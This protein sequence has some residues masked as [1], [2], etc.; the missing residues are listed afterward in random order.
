MK[1]VKRSDLP[2]FSPGQLEAVCKALADTDTGL[3]GT[4]I[5]QVLQQCRIAEFD[6]QA[7]KWRRLY[8]ALAQRLNKDQHS[9]A[10][11]NFITHSL[12]PARYGGKRD[13]FERRRR[14]VNLPLAFVGLEFGPDGKFRKVGRAS[15]LD[16]A[17]RRA[18]GLRS[19]L[20]D[21]NVHPDVLAYCRAELVAD[22]Y[23]HAVLEATKSVA[24][25]LRRLSGLTTDGSD[26]VD[27]ALLGRA[28]L[29]AINKLTSPSDWSEQRGFGSLVKGVFGTFRNP[30]A[31]EPRTEWAM[32]EE[33]ALDLLVIASY[34]HR[35]LDRS[36]KRT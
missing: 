22:N 9:N 30:T 33:D 35:R 19:A 13:S 4:E 12:D 34:A 20:T 24:V 8:G 23:F 36:S 14:E 28:P 15:T 17:E 25:K 1:Q 21:R 7:T 26:L 6:P 29:V 32:S 16:E 3:T 31:H 10:V 2:V 27:A 5:G 18:A 11:L